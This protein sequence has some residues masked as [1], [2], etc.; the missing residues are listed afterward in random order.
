MG[1][2]AVALVV[3]L[4]LVARVALAANP[5]GVAVIVG[6]RTYQG[7]LPAVT[8]AHRDADAVRHFVLDVLG[9]DPDNVIDLRDATK[10]QMEAAFGN[11]RDFKGKLWSYVDARGR[12]DI[13]VYYSGHGVPGQHDGRGYLLPVNADPDQ[14]EINGYPVDL[15]YANLAKLK[16][17][18]KTVLLDACF[19][20]DSPKGMLIRSASPVF[21]APKAAAPGP[22]LTVLTAAGGT[23]LASWDDEAQH[24][25]FT[26][27]FLRGVYGEADGDGDGAVTAAEVKAFLDD[28]MT[29]MAR[30]TYRRQQTATVLGDTAATLSAFPAGSPPARPRL[31]RLTERPPSAPPAADAETIFWQS[32]QASNR[33]EELEAYLKAYP[34]G[35]FAPLARARLDSLGQRA[36]PDAR[37]AAPA[38]VANF[39]G[40]WDTSYGQMVLAQRGDRVSGT[41][42]HNSGR[43]EGT[44]AGNTFTGQWRETVLIFSGSGVVEFEMADDGRSFSG[45]W[46]DVGGSAWTIWTGTR[47]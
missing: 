47:R 40:S 28:K 18:S 39:A 11:D 19:S 1:R 4:L 21:I 3:A 35:T 16:A 42:T 30:R 45:R 17:R 24:G 31:A 7:S 13:F 22:G 36:A 25:L 38:A 44:V 26:E 43:I 9:F 27:Y 15:L 32:V 20:G 41:Y 33:R 12:S 29:R 37:P 5:N 8:Y 6:N 2:F 23:E 10:A 34:N 46:R 14:A